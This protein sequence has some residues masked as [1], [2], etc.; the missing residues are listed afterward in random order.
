MAAAGDGRSVCFVTFA[1]PIV[2]KVACYV[3]MGL[4]YL[5]WRPDCTSILFLKI[6]KA[7][8]YVKLNS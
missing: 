3:G 4:E 7:F 1:L 8:N 2:L 6:F 5:V